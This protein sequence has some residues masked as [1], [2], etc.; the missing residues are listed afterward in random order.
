MSGISLLSEEQAKHD[1]NE[2]VQSLEEVVPFSF[3]PELFYFYRD[4][5]HWRPYYFILYK[6][7]KPI[8]VLPLVYTGRAYVSLP[9][10]SYGGWLVKEEVKES[11]LNAITI[12]LDRRKPV[13][14]F[15]RAE[16][17]LISIGEPSKLPLFVRGLMRLGTEMHPAKVTSLMQIPQK[18]EVLGAL[19]SSNLR[20]KIRKAK[21][22]NFIVRN[23]GEE[24]LADFYPVYAQRMHQL[25]SPAYGCS[26]FRKL[27]QQTPKEDTRIFVIYDGTR[28]IGGALLLSYR[29]FYESA[30]F[31]TDRK[32]MQFYISDYLH[33]KIIRYTIAQ[34]GMVYSMGRSTEQ[35]S[36]YKYKNHW[37][38]QH[39]P[40]YWYNTTN[41]PSVRNQLW[42]SKIWKNSPRFI[43]DKLGPVFIMHIY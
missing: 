12:F 22:K 23:G 4:G 30:W 6:E 29:G 16:D 19:L 27:I 32:Y 36:V 40:L 3:H 8:A 35:G 7:E 1:W 17:S 18:E 43:V 15:Y 11:L 14:G 37:P 42:L 38:M 34:G 20:R 39:H 31:A 21:Q 41:F 10:F 5:L 24:L 33:E 25:G 13:P 2:F 9:H 26:F 28:P